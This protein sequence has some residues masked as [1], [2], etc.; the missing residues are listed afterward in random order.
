MP[1]GSTTA[2][3]T[4]SATRPRHRLSQTRGPAHDADAPSV[5]NKKDR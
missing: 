5:G 1:D 4:T 3:L 2:S